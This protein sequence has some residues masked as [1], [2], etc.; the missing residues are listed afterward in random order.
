MH[1]LGETLDGGYRAWAVCG[2]V[3]TDFGSASGVDAVGRSAGWQGAMN[4][5][6]HA[7]TGEAGP[8]APSVAGT[9]P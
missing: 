3:I 1:D 6:Q 4:R 7:E 9:V 2:R 5:S 8:R